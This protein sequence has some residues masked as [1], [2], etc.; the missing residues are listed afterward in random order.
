MGI[1]LKKRN[2]SKRHIKMKLLSTVTALTLTSVKAY[3][4]YSWADSDHYGW[5]EQGYKSPFYLGKHY[6]NSLK[7]YNMVELQ[8][9]EENRNQIG[10]KATYIKADYDDIRHD[11]FVVLEE[12]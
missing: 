6:Q 4:R 12:V 10:L 11:P 1:I 5:I 2:Y 8:E 3:P 9:K 7:S